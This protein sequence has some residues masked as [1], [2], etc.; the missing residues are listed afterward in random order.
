MGFFYF[1]QKN[2]AEAG[3][4]R[5]RAPARQKR[6]IPERPPAVRFYLFFIRFYNFLAA[7]PLGAAQKTAFVTAL[8]PPSCRPDKISTVLFNPVADAADG[9]Y[10]IRHA[11]LL[12]LLAYCFYVHIHSPCYALK[13]IAPYA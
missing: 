8:R 1:K 12:E 9:C 7:Q 11:R 2:P 6:F 3:R 13:I 10:I 4:R 5:Q